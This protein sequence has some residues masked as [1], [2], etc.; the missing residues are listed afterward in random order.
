MSG[1]MVFYILA[2]IFAAMV[3]IVPFILRFR[4]RVLR[5]LRWPRLAAWHE[6]NARPIVFGVRLILGA[7]AI[8]LVVIAASS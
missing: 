2:A 1:D 5:F 4:I 3:P 6:R 7:L 8:V